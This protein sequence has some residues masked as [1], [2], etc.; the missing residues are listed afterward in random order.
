MFSFEIPYAVL[1][2]IAQKGKI[3]ILYGTQTGT[4]EDFSRTLAREAKK[5]HIY[6]K[7]VDMEVYDTVCTTS[8]D[9]THESLS[10]ITY[11]FP[12][13]QIIHDTFIIINNNG[14]VAST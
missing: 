12:Y 6:A 5:Y 9:H 3:K 8:T 4:A 14:I 10:T 13:Q 1:T 2:V 7:I 11:Q